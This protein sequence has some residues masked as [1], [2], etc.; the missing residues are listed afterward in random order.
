[1]FAMNNSVSWNY[2]SS[3]RKEHLGYFFF[4]YQRKFIK[5]KA[6]LQMAQAEKL[7][8]M[9]IYGEIPIKDLLKLERMYFHFKSLNMY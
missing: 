5:T 1:M 6:I 4:F 8:I 2:D 9:D 7:F 3:H